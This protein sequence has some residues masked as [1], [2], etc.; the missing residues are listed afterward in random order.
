MTKTFSF[1]GYALVLIALQGCAGSGPVVATAGQNEPVDRSADY[2]IGPGDVLQ[3]YVWDNPELTV[4]IPV[5][6]DGMIT[7]PL[8]EDMR[9][10]SKTPTQLARDVE[11]K[12]SEYVRTPQVNIIVTNFRGTYQKQ[13]RVVGQAVSP[14]SLSFQSGMTLLDVMIEVGGL[15]E[16]AAG[17]RAKVI[18]WENN[19]QQEIR[20]RLKDLISDGDIR[21]NI[22]MK[23]G[24]V[25]IIPESIF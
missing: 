18:R 15:T 3:V 20:V 19:E 4:T 2:I 11:V 7:I 21:E 22:D 9:A 5:R 16:F 6:P 14:Q 10:V 24:D 17:N 12:L 1:F 25:L 23:P 13:I 8:V